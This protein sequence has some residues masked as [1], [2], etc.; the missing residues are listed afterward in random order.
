MSSRRFRDRMVVEF[1]TIYLCNQCLSPLSFWVRIPLRRGVLETTLSDIVCQWLAAGRWFSP[2]TPASSLYKTDRHDITEI[3][4][5]MALNTIILT[6]KQN[7]YKFSTAF[8]LYWR[9]FYIEEYCRFK[10]SI[11]HESFSLPF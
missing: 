5:R 3:L 4:L 7:A 8:K 9:K 10:I 6:L 1:K 11:Y 2:G